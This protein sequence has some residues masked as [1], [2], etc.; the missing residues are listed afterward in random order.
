MS[1]VVHTQT[2]SYHKID[3]G[4]HINS[5]TPEVDKPT[6]IHLEIECKDLSFQKN[7]FYQSEK[8]AGQDQ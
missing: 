5:Q 4:D 8:D 6:N 2:H 7:I 3:T 1:T